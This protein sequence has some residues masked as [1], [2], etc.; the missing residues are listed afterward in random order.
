M[1]DWALGTQREWVTMGEPSI[2][3]HGIPK[4]LMFGFPGTTEGCRYTIVQ[5]LP[6]D[7]YSQECTKEYTG[8]TAG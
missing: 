8:R 1:H 5:G 7:A 2:G 3:D 6:I 4:D